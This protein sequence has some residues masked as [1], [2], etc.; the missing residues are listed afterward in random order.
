M[1][2]QGREHPVDV[3]N[4]KGLKIKIAADPVEHFFA[5]FVVGVVEGLYQIIKP[6][7]APAI[8]RWAREL[9]IRAN[10]IRRIRV[11]WKPLLQDDTMLPGIAK[12][13]RVNGLG[14]DPPPYA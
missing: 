13:V 10:R 9:T 7:N 4:R 2:A 1:P 11:I 5:P 14:A 6:G 8:L 3:V 12:I